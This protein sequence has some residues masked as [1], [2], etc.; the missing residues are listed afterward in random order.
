MKPKEKLYS[1]KGKLTKTMVGY[2]KSALETLPLDE[3]YQIEIKPYKKDRSGA[4]RRLQ[5]VWYTHIREEGDR[6]ET[7]QEIENYCKYTFGIP[8]LKRDN[9]RFD[10]VWHNQSSLMTYEHELAAMEFL[11][12]TRLFTIS[13]NTEY[14]EE[15]KKHYQLNGIYLPSGDDL[16]ADAMGFDRRTK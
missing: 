11:P 14:L 15:C 6:Q 13:Q 3:T 5:H 16:Y 8:I 10:Q 12:V 1:L 2:V 9:E 7:K 4:Q